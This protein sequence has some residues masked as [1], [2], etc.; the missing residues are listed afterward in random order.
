M[1]HVDVLS[2]YFICGAGSLVGA[3]ML[4]IAEASD[5]RTHR[6]LRLCGWGFV[7][8][9]LGLMPSGLG[10]SV[11]ALAAA[12]FSLGF[13][14]L[15]GML[16]IGAGLGEVQ[17]KRLRARAIAAWVMCFA[18]G[19]AL[20]LHVGRHTFGIAF[21]TGMVVV[22]SMMTW[23]MRGMI[24]HGRDATERAMAASMMVLVVSCWMRWAFTLA[25]TGG[26][27]ADLMYLPAPYDSALAALYGV[28]PMIVATLMLTLVNSRLRHQLRV[29]A[30][31]DELTGTM[32]RRA[33][34][35]LAPSLVQQ[36]HASQRDVAV[37]MLDLDRFK[38]IN[39]TYGHIKGDAV[40]RMA[41]EVLQA[42]ARVDT[43]L[44]R[45]GGEEFIAVVPVD[46]LP[47]ARRVAE[48]LR[49]AI[50][51]ADWVGALGLGS[52]VTV[53]VGVAVV[54]PAE[55]LDAALQRA[56]EALY[57]AKRDGRNQCQIGLAVA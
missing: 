8:L 10:E 9:G 5:A 14:T 44:A 33:L 19:L 52:G 15:T 27:R 51:G 43:L 36:Q 11:A 12:Q 22:A 46:D 55:P 50:E 25:D 28:L 7:V 49:Q 35:E 26:V 4:R 56:D 45:Y 34:R 6:A 42:H 31:T 53:S 18:L 2:G 32:T 39:D 16:L 38:A 41:A 23:L 57:R 54:G 29:R 1:L 13:G 24:L 48:R 17:G 21:V 40:L 30:I 20:A 37:L 3:A 47:A